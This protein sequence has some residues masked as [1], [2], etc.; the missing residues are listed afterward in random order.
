M[1]NERNV[2]DA[3][4]S[5]DSIAWDGCHKIYILMD[6]TQ[7]EK[8]REYKYEYVFNANEY[9]QFDL[10]II[11]E[12]WFKQSCGLRLISACSTAEDGDTADFTQLVRQGEEEESVTA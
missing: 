3:L 4:S 11:L 2:R 9:S 6:I 8:M 12:S 1:I 5:A 10:F 7:T